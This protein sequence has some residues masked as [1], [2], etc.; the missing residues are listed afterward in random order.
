MD[1]QKKK[2]IR[3]DLELTSGA[4]QSGVPS[5]DSSARMPSDL[6]LLRPK[7]VSLAFQ[8]SSTCVKV[9]GWGGGMEKSQGREMSG[10]ERK[11]PLV[12]PFEE[13]RQRTRED[14]IERDETRIHANDRRQ[15]LWPNHPK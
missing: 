10:L 4:C 7:S 12:R 14:K 2:I 5:L 8:L 11:K 3:L 1:G 13:M 6:T 9:R 15:R